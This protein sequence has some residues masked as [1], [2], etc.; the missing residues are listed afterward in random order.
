MVTLRY[1][2][3][4]KNIITLITSFDNLLFVTNIYEYADCRSVLNIQEKNFG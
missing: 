1:V 4:L 2:V 3:R